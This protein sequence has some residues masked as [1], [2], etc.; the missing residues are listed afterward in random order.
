MTENGQA[1]YHCR[2]SKRTC[3]LIAFFTGNFEEETDAG[4]M[5]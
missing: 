3:L 1:S 4:Q 2:D 5:D